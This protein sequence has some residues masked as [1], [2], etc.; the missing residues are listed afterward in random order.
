MYAMFLTVLYKEE[1]VYMTVRNMA[2][3]DRPSFIAELSSA[4]GFS[5]VEK[6]NQCRDFLSTVLDKHSPAYLMKVINHKSSP[7]FESIRD[8]R[9]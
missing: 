3:I 5:S 2:Y 7:W 6:A 9:L 1:T 4:T 8:D